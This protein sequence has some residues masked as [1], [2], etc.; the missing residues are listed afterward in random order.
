MANRW[1][2]DEAEYYRNYSKIETTPMK[3]NTVAENSSDDEDDWI[4]AN[5]AFQQRIVDHC[6]FVKFHVGIERVCHMDL[7]KLIKAAD[8][9]G[10]SVRRLVQRILDAYDSPDTSGY[11]DCDPVIVID[12][13][14]YVQERLANLDNQAEAADNPVV[15]EEAD[16][17]VV[18]E[19]E[20][21]NPI[22][23]E[24][25]EIDNPIVEEEEE[26]DNPIEEEEEEEEEE[27]DDEAK[28][29]SDEEDMNW[30]CN[31]LDPSDD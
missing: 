2:D 9:R 22:V 3:L 25:E 19:E 5:K 27:S 4:P 31:A 26:P 18:E 20:I 8:L 30:C 17:P 28:F 24:E 23:E 14:N 1:D 15:Q 16:N 13:P 6:E 11:S 29:D 21:E 12:N 7:V 10:V